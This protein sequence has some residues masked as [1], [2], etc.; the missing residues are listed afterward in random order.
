MKD[1]IK[2]KDI[3]M[4]VLDKERGTTLP[5][6]GLRW[7]GNR[8]AAIQVEIGM[9]N[10]YIQP[11]NAELYLLNVQEADQLGIMKKMQDAGFRKMV[12]AELEKYE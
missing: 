10:M 6:T 4:E 12:K 7:E 1:K 11:R 9:S 8:I 3:K 5:V 2:I